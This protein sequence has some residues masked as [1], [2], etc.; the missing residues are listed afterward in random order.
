LELWLALLQVTWPT[1]AAKRIAWPKNVESLL[2][3][4]YLVPIFPTCLLLLTRAGQ[5]IHRSWW[6]IVEPCDTNDSLYA[7][8]LAG[9][10][11]IQWAVD[12]H[13]GKAILYSKLPRVTRSYAHFA[14]DG[15]P[16]VMETVEK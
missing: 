13:K 9:G 14:L 15:R 5:A 2:L 1:F 3:K 12:C 7:R 11:L 6:R 16:P 4:T 8:V 10:S